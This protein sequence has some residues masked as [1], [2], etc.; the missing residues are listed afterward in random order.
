MHR[1]E[2]PLPL[3]EA[4]EQQYI[5]NNG[6]G[7]QI[8]HC[9]SCGSHRVIR[10]QGNGTL[11]PPPFDCEDCNSVSLAPQWTKLTELQTKEKVKSHQV[12]P[13]TTS[14]I[15]DFKV[16]LK[17]LLIKYDASVICNLDGDTH[18]LLTEMEIEVGDESE[19]INDS[20]H[21]NPYDIK[22]N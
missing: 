20:T 17:A 22:I 5:Y 9:T 18:D 14:N 2:L 16:E 10:R 15:N 21:L 12:T 19:V 4:V 13:K 1:S 8:H 6:F 7:E 11:S 3:L